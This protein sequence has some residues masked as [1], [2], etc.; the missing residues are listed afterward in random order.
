[1]PDSR[2][3]GGAYLSGEA[4]PIVA[5]KKPAKKPGGGGGILLAGV[6]VAA[7]GAGSGG[8]FAITDTSSSGHGIPSSYEQAY[9]SAAADSCLGSDWQV[10]AGIGYVESRHGRNGGTSSAGAEGPMQFMPATWRAYG[11]GSPWSIHDA[12]RAAARYLCAHGGDSYSGIYAYNHSSAYVAK[13][14]SAAARYR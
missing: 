8:S 10:L 2:G 4:A 14:R 9:K 3:A 5:P 6:V 12:S 1:M 13:V 11:H 7:L